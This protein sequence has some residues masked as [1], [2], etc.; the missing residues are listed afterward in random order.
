MFQSQ[1]DNS[2]ELFF[3]NQVKYENY[4]TKMDEKDQG[5]SKKYSKEFRAKGG[6]RGMATNFSEKMADTE[7]M[8]HGISSFKISFLFLKKKDQL[9]QNFDNR[10]HIF[11]PKILR[12]LNFKTNF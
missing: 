9:T 6:G 1:L 12:A 2:T 8:P 10:K 3:H 7:V 5:D 11:G 4:R